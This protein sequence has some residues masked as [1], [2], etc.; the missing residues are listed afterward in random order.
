LFCF[1]NCKAKDVVIVSMLRSCIVFG[2]VKPKN[3]DWLAQKGYWANSLDKKGGFRLVLRINRYIFGGKRSHWSIWIG[4]KFEFWR[5]ITYFR[6]TTSGSG[7]LTSGDVTILIDPPQILIELY[8]YTTGSCFRSVVFQ[9]NYRRMGAIYLCYNKKNGFYSHLCEGDTVFN[10]TTNV[11]SVTEF[12]TC[13]EQQEEL[14]LMYTIA[15]TV[16]KVLCVGWGMRVYCFWNC[17]T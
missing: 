10:A 6:F 5:E 9:Y 2:T 7:D 15:V 14:N 11:S 4:G 12:A 13:R 17:K 16:Q 3:D 1:W 8:P